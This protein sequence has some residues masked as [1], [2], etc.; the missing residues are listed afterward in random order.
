M[1]WLMFYSSLLLLISFLWTT[2]GNMDLVKA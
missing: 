2:L 1:I